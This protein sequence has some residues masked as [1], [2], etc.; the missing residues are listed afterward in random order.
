MPERADPWS[1]RLRSGIGPLAVIAFAVAFFAPVLFGH[2]V[3]MTG[4]MMRWLPWSEDATVAEKAAP[5]FNPDCNLSYYPRRAVL[6]DAWNERALPLWNPDT[7][8]GSP[9][10]AD[11]Q[12]GVFYPPNW[13]LMPFDPKWQMGAFLF[14]HAAWGGLGLHALLRRLG[15][16][17]PLAALAGCAFV[18]NGYFFQN[19]GLPTFLASASWVPWM[20]AAVLDLRQRPDAYSAAMLGICAALVFLAGQPQTAVHAA[21]AGA[22]VLTVGGILRARTMRGV[23][24]ALAAVCVA[25]LLAAAQLLPTAQLAKAS[26]RADLPYSTIVSGAFHPVEIIRFA[27]DGFFGSPVTEDSWGG[28]FPRGD[29]FYFRHQASSVF[30]GTPVFILALWGIVAKGTRQKA[31]AFTILFVL[32]ALIAFGSPLAH[33]VYEILPGFRFSRIDRFG[34]FVVFAQAVLAAMAAQDFASRP[35]AWR[36]R[37]IWGLIVIA[38]AIAGAMAVSLAGPELPRLLGAPSREGVTMRLDPVLFDRVVERTRIAALFAIA[39]GIT[40]ALPSARLACTAPWVLAA[41]QLSFLAAPHRG[42]RHPESVFAP[43]ESLAMLADVLDEGEG[44]GRFIRYGR[45]PAT[46]GTP[47]SNVLPPSTNVPYGLPDVQGYN[48]LADTTLGRVLETA[49]GEKVFTSGIWMGR[50]I[51]EPV[52]PRSMEHPLL[53]AL[54]VR[55]AVS[56]DSFSAAGWSNL[57]VH[58]F[59]LFRNNE[60]CPRFS[61]VAEG[62]G[63]GAGEMNEILQRG[64]FNPHRQAMWIGT[65]E[66]RSTEGATSTGTVQTLADNDREIVVRA[67]SLRPAIFIVADS[68]NSG[69]KAKVDGNPQEILRVWGVIRGVVLQPGS[70]LVEMRYEPSAFRIGSLLSIAGLFLTGGMLAWPRPPR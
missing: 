12:A 59:H 36:Q 21:Y 53:D 55:A 43:H 38:F 26:A 8:A 68:W 11:V 16:A 57:P 63:V 50:R 10:L 30:A 18:L 25:L 6:H 20:L 60:A 39:T 3:A 44:G 49:L 69:W 33:L 52:L 2:R 40:L 27:V 46:R 54:A 14:F 22:L 56:A 70:H 62:R 5:S 48:A 13:V 41:I 65:G 15:I 64:A 28:L 42:D 29:S 35:S 24:A 19:F 1:G 67:T 23:S 34:F 7:F 9:F 31:M 45:D 66:L 47:V 32:S 37:R 58:G 17:A 51:V 61:L 4:N